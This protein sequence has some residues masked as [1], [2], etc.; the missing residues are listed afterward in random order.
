MEAMDMPDVK[1]CMPAY[2]EIPDVGLFL[3]QTSKY[4]TG[5]LSPC[6]GIA[7]TPSMISNYVKQKLLDHP[8][9]K[10]YSRDQIAELIVISLLKTV[11]TLDEIRLLLSAVD[12]RRETPAVYDSVR[13]LLAKAMQEL[14]SQ[15]TPAPSGDAPDAPEDLLRATILTVAHKIS[16]SRALLHFQRRQ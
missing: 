11:L 5:C 8:V 6:A 1:N 2:R 13:D 9:K 14:S 16:L 4:V 15:Q 12:I 7:L 10:Q 3:E